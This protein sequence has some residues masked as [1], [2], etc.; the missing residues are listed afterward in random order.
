V[1]DVAYEGRFPT[2]CC[3][4]VDQ[5]GQ[6]ERGGFVIPCSVQKLSFLLML[7]T[8]IKIGPVSRPPL[9]PRNR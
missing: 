7:P 4:S 2:Q 1:N 9:P 5:L 8:L 6:I 3:G